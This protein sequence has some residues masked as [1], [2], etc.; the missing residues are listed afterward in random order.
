MADKD[1]SDV[2]S[3]FSDTSDTSYQSLDDNGPF[4]V[5]YDLAHEP[6]FD[7]TNFTVLHYNV[8]SITAQGRLEELNYYCKILNISVLV[9]TESKLDETVPSNILLQFPCYQ[10]CPRYVR[11]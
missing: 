6:P 1:L 5:N 3:N 8:K 10:L 9:C 4:A 11:L 7:I 2:W